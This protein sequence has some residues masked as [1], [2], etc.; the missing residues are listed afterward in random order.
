MHKFKL[1]T[2]FYNE[3]FK[4]NFL[5]TLS[6]IYL[7]RLYGSEAQK[8]IGILFWYKLVTIGIVFYAWV[9]YKKKQLYYYQ[10]LG[11]TSL[12]LLITTSVFDFLL[13][14]AIIVFHMTYGTR[15]DIFM[16]IPVLML[17]VY[18]YLNTKK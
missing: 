11:I 5:V 7:L 14:L 15:V 1:I 3:I 6:C 8:I 12:Q 2:R 13:W 4:A 9:S 18:L 17:M 10:N 16:V